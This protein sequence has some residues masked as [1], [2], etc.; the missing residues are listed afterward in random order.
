MTK[1]MFRFKRISSTLF[2]HD[3]VS[4]VEFIV[5][6]RILG[7]CK[8]GDPEEFESGG[9]CSRSTTFSDIRNSLNISKAAV[10]QILHALKRKGRIRME[11]D[12]A[13]RRRIVLSLTQD[14]CSVLDDMNRRV[15]H[16]MDETVS[17]FGEENMLTFIGM[18]DRFADII[19]TIGQER[20]LLTKERG[21]G[22]F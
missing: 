12:P 10:S 21:N 18:F 4:F 14:G 6:M 9:G 13:D 2:N 19:H 16:I 20:A 5:M 7:G 22:K 3:E 17:R 1:S 11:S 15:T 8:Y